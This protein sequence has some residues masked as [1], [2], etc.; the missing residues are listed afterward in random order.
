[1]S[2]RI[3]TFAGSHV[4]SDNIL[5]AE[6]FS[7]GISLYLPA[8]RFDWTFADE[9]KWLVSVESVVGSPT[10]WSLDIDFQYAI[11]NTRGG[12]MEEPRWFTLDA[13]SITAD[14][15]EGVTFG[16]WKNGDT[17]PRA[18][19]RTIRN[20]GANMRILLKPSFTGGTDPGLRITVA[21]ESKGAR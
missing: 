17:L 1:M 5:R 11:P 21:A 12:R 4:A 14:I 8:A 18:Q 3:H 7:S 16:Q 6:E 13:A 15:A 2:G 20:F 9:V 10:A 19:K